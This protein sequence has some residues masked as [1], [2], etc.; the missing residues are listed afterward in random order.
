MNSLLDNGQL[1]LSHTQPSQL[2]TTYIQG[3]KMKIRVRF[4]RT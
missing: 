3:T 1:S 4:K 2:E